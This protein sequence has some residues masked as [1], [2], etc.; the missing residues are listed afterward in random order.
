MKVI[1]RIC[2]EHHG[3]IITEDLR[4]I[5][6]TKLRSLLSKGPNFREPNTI[7]YSKCK[8]AIDSR[9]DNCIQKL[10]TKH[11]LRDNDLNDWNNF[12]RQK[13]SNRIKNVRRN[14]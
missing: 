13:V 5:T 3:H 6:N 2:G 11:K 12:A 9:T 1:I 8:I 14:N 4:L 10:K 7:K